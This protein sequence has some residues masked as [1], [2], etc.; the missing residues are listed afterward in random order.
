MTFLGVDFIIEILIGQGASRMAN[1]TQSDHFRKVGED[2]V[3]SALILQC[4]FFLV[5]IQF[6][7]QFQIACSKKGVLK[8]N[9]RTVLYV[10]YASAALITIRCIYRIVEFFEG[11]TGEIYDTEWFFWVFEATLM[12]INTALLNVFHPGK[13]LPPGTRTFL[14]PDGVTE[15]VGPGWEDNRHP[16]LKIFDICDFVGLVRRQDKKNRYWEWDPADLDA[17]VARQKAEKAEKKRKW[18]RLF[19]FGRRQTPETDSHVAPAV[20]TAGFESNEQSKQHGSHSAQD[21]V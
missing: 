16:L 2:L 15:R 14:A 21:M 11:Y 18:A 9:L 4:I 6:G 10:M 3:K 8:K 20:K 13:Y 19:T 1:T 7:V 17:F 12:F 5:F